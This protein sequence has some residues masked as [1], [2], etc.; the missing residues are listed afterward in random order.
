MTTETKTKRT[1]VANVRGL[2]PVEWRKDINHFYV[3]RHVHI[4]TGKFA[5]RTWGNSCFG[6]PFRFDKDATE[7]EK[8]LL[9]VNYFQHM[10]QQLGCYQSIWQSFKMLPGKT[11]GC[12]CCDWPGQELDPQ[13]YKPLPLCHAA[14]LAALVD[15]YFSPE[16]QGALVWRQG[17]VPFMGHHTPT[18]RVVL[19]R[20]N[21]SDHI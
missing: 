7:D 17:V 2:D 21:P 16:W 8:R 12:W 14:W 9:L 6:N 1:T 13:N 19:F 3:G 10:K 11:L 5:R 20:R 15:I 4:R 18:E